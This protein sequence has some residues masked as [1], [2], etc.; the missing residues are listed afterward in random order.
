MGLL[1]VTLKRRRTSRK[2]F[3]K[4]G[5][6]KNI[7]SEKFLFNSE[8]VTSSQIVSTAPLQPPLPIAPAEPSKTGDDSQ[9]TAYIPDLATHG[10]NIPPAIA[11]KRD[12]LFSSVPESERWKIQVDEVALYSITEGRLAEQQSELFA[13]IIGAAATITDATACVGGNTI[14]F[15]RHFAHVNSVELSV[16]RSQMLQNNV[17]VVGLHDKVTVYNGDYT[18]LMNTLVQDA[19]FFDPPW[20]GPDYY[21]SN[22]LDMF[23]GPHN[24]IDIIRKLLD[25]RRATFVFMKAPLNYNER[26]LRQ[27]LADV[28]V[29]TKHMMHKMQIFV[30][31]ALVTAT[32]F[33][34]VVLP[35]LPAPPAAAAPAAAPA[36]STSYNIPAF[37]AAPINIPLNLGQIQDESKAVSVDNVEDEPKAV[38]GV[39]A[40]LTCD[41]MPYSSTELITPNIVSL[42][43]FNAPHNDMMNWIRLQK[44]YY[45]TFQI[46]LAISDAIAAPNDVTLVEFGKTANIVKFNCPE[47]TNV[48]FSQLFDLPSSPKG[49]VVI[50]NIKPNEKHIAEFSKMIHNINKISLPVDFFYSSAYSNVKAFPDAEIKF[51]RVYGNSCAAFTRLPAEYF[52][53]YA[54]TTT[55]NQEEAYLNDYLL[56]EL[57]KTD[58]IIAFSRQYNIAH[59]LREYR[60]DIAKYPKTLNI[61]QYVLHPMV[62]LNRVKPI[63]TIEAGIKAFE[64]LFAK[65]SHNLT[66][67]ESDAMNLVVIRYYQ[68]V[69]HMVLAGS[70][71][72]PLDTMADIVKNYD[73]IIIKNTIVYTRRGRVIATVPYMNVGVSI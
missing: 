53:N 13:G 16:Q 14:S 20:G 43:M 71:W 10:A 23:L 55:D 39:T 73:G 49:V 57:V 21:K 17:D 25:E 54:S 1:P 62:S 45:P 51:P 11:S 35:N 31:K 37:I 6:A 44:L 47:T 18:V 36:A 56:P 4:R 19:V 69:R 22:A 46:K 40:P 68:I 7:T 26:D 41:F 48:R 38:P 70:G 64:Q 3:S 33:A 8:S 12:Y 67:F 2:R 72:I 5:G 59:F 42:T 50:Q 15:A 27:K 65:P 52:N 32:S 34:S 9:S 66:T 24:I 58:K 63:I 30:I 60:D 61:L 28:A 29:I